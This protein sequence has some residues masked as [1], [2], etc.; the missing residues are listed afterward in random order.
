MGHKHNEINTD[1]NDESLEEEIININPEKEKDNSEVYDPV[2]ESK[3]KEDSIYREVNF[4]NDDSNIKA[5]TYNLIQN[6]FL[7][8]IRDD[9]YRS[10]LGD[11]HIIDND[12]F[13]KT[14]KQNNIIDA[15]A[16]LNEMQKAKPFAI[17]TRTK[18]LDLN[19]AIDEYNNVVNNFNKRRFDASYALDQ[20]DKFVKASV[21][22]DLTTELRTPINKDTVIATYNKYLNPIKTI[23]DNNIEEL[24]E[25]A[26]NKRSD[27]LTYLENDIFIR[28]K[29]FTKRQKDKFRNLKMK[30]KNM[31][32]EFANSL[33]EGDVATMLNYSINNMVGFGYN[34]ETYTK[35]VTNN[36]IDINKPGVA[37][38]AVGK[39]ELLESIKALKGMDDI[40]SA[41]P[42][43]KKI[44][45][46]SHNNQRK[47]L[48][49][50]K[51]ALIDRGID[52]KAL[53]KYLSSDNDET[54]LNDIWTKSKDKVN[55]FNKAIL[56][57]DEYLREEMEIKNVNEQI[58][59]FEKKEKKKQ[60]IN[61]IEGVQLKEDLKFD[62]KDV[63]DSDED[64]DKE[65]FKNILNMEFDIKEDFTKENLENLEERNPEVDNSDLDLSVDDLLE[66]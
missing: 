65:N 23:C 60:K 18:E 36:I 45:N 62:E 66:K 22:K 50:A 10:E 51:Q 11:T 5:D 47:I 16:E 42:W 27:S 41:K 43:Y 15:R 48:D 64:L 39:D 54:L 31:V 9:L 33:T 52:K 6:L 25:E 7:S 13:S 56:T 44:F 58:K 32:K 35:E 55:E 59:S 20:V 46:K 8:F 4:N 3:T 37:S 24:D 40:V 14:Y 61:N 38:Y 19:N 49:N 29:R 57:K 2:L 17:E 53:E 21:F 26:T 63:I 34:F 1:L 28:L 12:K 30:E